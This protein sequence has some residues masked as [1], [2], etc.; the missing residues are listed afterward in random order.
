M[1]GYVPDLNRSRSFSRPM[2][3]LEEELTGDIYSDNLDNLISNTVVDE[4]SVIAVA[5]S[6]RAT[7][8]SVGRKVSVD[9]NV[10]FSLI[11]LFINVTNST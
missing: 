4:L 3:V 6:A 9:I 5:D 1:K 7:S 11:L 8:N 2:S 10:G